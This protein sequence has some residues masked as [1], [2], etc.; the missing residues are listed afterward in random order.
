MATI[1]SPRIPVLRCDIGT[2]YTLDE[3]RVHSDCNAADANKM[4]EFKRDILL[5]VL[6]VQ[7]AT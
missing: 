7:I 4:Y 2:T 1:I 3:C 5:N 6:N